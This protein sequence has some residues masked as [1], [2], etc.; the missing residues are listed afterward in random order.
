M[1]G[2]YQNKRQ[3]FVIFLQDWINKVVSQKLWERFVDLHIDE[4]DLEFE[5]QEKWI[6]GSIYIM[7]CIKTLVD[8]AKYDVILVIPLSCLSHSLPSVDFKKMSDLENELDYLTPPSFYLFPKGEVNYEETI[9]Q[10]RYLDE[11]SQNENLKVYYNEIQERNE[12]YRTIYV[13][14]T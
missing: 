5:S 9:L 11:L 7:N 4:I 2:L 12:I 10:S 6:S 3:Y 13:R 14:V 8:N 1:D